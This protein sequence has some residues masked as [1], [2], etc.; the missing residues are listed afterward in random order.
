[1]S[2][3]LTRFFERRATSGGNI[4]SAKI[5]EM[6]RGGYDSA[7]GI[8]VSEESSLRSTAVFAADHLSPD[9]ARQVA[10]A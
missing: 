9:A 8:H 7:T 4:N 3:I 6:L 1:M 5:I 10:R 2:G